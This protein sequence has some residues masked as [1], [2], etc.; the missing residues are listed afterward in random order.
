MGKKSRAKK[1]AAA[2]TAR[3]TGELEGLINFIQQLMRDQRHA[4]ASRAGQALVEQFPLNP[5]AH[6]VLGSVLAQFNNGQE[7]LRQFELA[8]RLGMHDDPMLLQNIAVSA[9]SARYPVH[10]LRAARDGLRLQ[11]T[12]PEQR[13]VFNT[14]VAVAEEYLRSLIGSRPIAPVL[15]EETMLLVEQSTR[16]LGS[17]EPE[18]ARRLAEEATERV[19]DWP[20][21]WNHLAILRFQFADLPGARAACLQVLTAV[22]AEDPLILSTLVRLHA[23]AGHDGEAAATLRLLLALPDNGVSLAEEKARALAVLERDQEIYDHLA[24]LGGDQPDEQA[25]HPVGRYLLGI[26]AANLGKLDDA[27]VA[28][29]NV[30]REGLAQARI[31][32]DILARHEQPP[33]PNG[34]FSYFAAAELVPATLLDELATRVHPAQD[35]ARL[36]EIADHFPRL[37]EALCQTFYAQGVDPR[38]AIDLLLPLRDRDAGI[39][40]AVRTFASSRAS[41]DHNRIYAHLALRAAGQDD[42]SAPASVWLGGRRRAIVLP[43]VRLSVPPER[44]RSAEI[45]RLFSQAAEAQERDEA[46]VAA[47]LYRRILEIDPESAEAEHNLGTALLLSADFEEGARHLQRALDLDPDHVL[48]RCNLASLALTRSDLATAHAL[49]DPLDQREGFSLEAV[50]AYLRTRSDLAH[51]DGDDARAEALLYALLAFD[52]E[53]E[54]AR[55]RIGALAQA[56]AAVAR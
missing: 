25:L 32:G 40:T 23:V 6:A 52:P 56:Q 31:Y 28:W 48:A 21:V 19:P 55:E 43:A 1:A 37:P 54:L 5:L 27:R 14:I 47:D 39:I 36:N 2:E 11:S 42:A 17:G 22:D 4:E 38:I 9:S 35:E 18:R 44:A 29:R 41:G 10:A 46:Q 16:A 51:A 24:P 3:P 26:A 49:L 45:E 30:W 33:T 15:A 53:N 34:R 12:T 7:S 13:Q 8:E 20:I 50:I